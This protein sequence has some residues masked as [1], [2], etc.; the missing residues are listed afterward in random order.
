MHEIL[1]LLFLI[2]FFALGTADQ[3]HEVSRPTSINI[4][5]C[6]VPGARP[7]T[8]EKV[9]CG[10]Y[11]VFE[12][13]TAMSGR[14][15]KLKIV[16]FPATGENPA[17]DPVFYI[18]GGPGSSATEEAPFIAQE[19]SK[20]RE[21]RDLVFVDQRGTGGSNPLNC[22]LY[23]PKNIN[24]YLGSYFPLDDVRRCRQQVESIADLRF[25]GTHVAM[26]DLEE[27]RVALGYKQINIGAV[28]YGTRAALIYLKRHPSS[29]RAMLL[30][31]ALPT[32]QP[33]PRDFPQNT[34]RALNGILSDCLAD[35]E[36]SAAFPNVRDD[37]KAV[38]QRLISGA[39][40]V[41][42]KDPR[43]VA[44]RIKLNRDLAAETIRYMLYSSTGAGRVPLF[45]HLAATGNFTPLAES[46]LIY[47]KRLATG[48]NGM[49]L[50]VTCSED[51]PWI[52]PG[53]RERDAENIFLGNYR[54][55]Q[56]RAACEIWPRAEVPRDFH[57]STRANTNV[58][59]LTGQWDPVTPPIYGDIAAKNLPNSLH[60]VVPNGGH[61]F[62]GLDGLSC[63]QDLNAR[64]IESGSVRGLDTSCVK[65]I[66]RRAFLLKMPENR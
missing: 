29:V 42:V 27:A 12:N 63:I 40:E 62:G 46:A 59:I 35:K 4:E 18:A 9:R 10:T 57:K 34:E 30:Q 33:M 13:R 61:G 64:F 7:N 11:E 36:C 19:W 5:P 56:Q 50:A 37:A 8:K 44:T 55:R 21:R 1:Q 39:V 52:K 16:V 28:S 15:I 6:E 25:Y 23:D 43:A 49:Y 24:S 3:S 51:L 54:L 14:T 65:N 17:P 20:I 26:D 41:D 32:S 22:E 45:L 66:R 2:T 58:L 60:V 48:A 53:E 38:L 47:R 31:G